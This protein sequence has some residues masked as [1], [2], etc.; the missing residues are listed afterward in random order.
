MGLSCLLTRSSAWPESPVTIWVSSALFSVCDC[1]LVCECF[2]WYCQQL[3][4]SDFAFSSAANEESRIQPHVLKSCLMG[5]I[6]LE[7]HCWLLTNFWGY[8]CNLFAAI[9]PFCCVLLCLFLV[10]CC[11]QQETDR[12][13]GFGCW[14]L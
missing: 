1:L 5:H 2:V 13:R 4:R 6:F 7:L 10:C 3:V 9:L 12:A 11:L 14:P 8:C